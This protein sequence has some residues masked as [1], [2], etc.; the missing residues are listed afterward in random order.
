MSAGCR[1]VALDGMR[2]LVMYPASAAEQPVSLGPYEVS[3]AMDA[4]VSPGE[5]PLVVISHGNNGSHLLY[6]ELALHLARN[7]FVVALP[8]HPGNNRDDRSLSG[9]VENLANRPRHLRA[10]IDFACSE[11]RISSV[12]VVGHSLG[13]YTGLALVGGKPTASPH[14]TGGEPAP[15]AVEADDRVTALVLLAP[16]TPWFMLDGAL[17]DVSVPILMLSGEKDENTTLWHADIVLKG[18]RGPVE[19]RVVE[20][21]NHFS[22][23]SPFPPHLA[24]QFAPYQDPPGFDRAAYQEEMKAEVLEFLQRYARK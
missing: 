13:G 10:V 20:N 3:A 2:V 23:E 6:R 1:S 12:A 4:P 14:E 8:E 21:A 5:F 7:G 24:S 19:H 17:D 11:W 15:V 18:V 22:F 16:A 9:T